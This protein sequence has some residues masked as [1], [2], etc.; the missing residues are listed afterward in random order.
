MVLA[1]EARAVDKPAD[2][3]AL[4]T[5]DM[6]VYYNTFRAVKNVNLLVA[7]QKITALIGPSGCGKSTVVNLLLRFWDPQ[8]GRILFDG[9][10]VRDVTLS[11][12]RGQI[13]L[14]RPDE[15]IVEI[16]N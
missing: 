6:A 5:R 1:V 16:E 9:T 2:N 15:V 7:P 3:C 11:S 8:R 13:G 12:L 14:V 4:E 10:D